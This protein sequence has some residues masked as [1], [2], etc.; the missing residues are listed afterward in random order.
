MKRISN[1]LWLL[2][3]LLLVMM[4]S[5]I[6]HRHPSPRRQPASVGRPFMRL[7]AFYSNSNI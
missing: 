2:A 4:V 5:R 7:A 6:G 1:A 3:G